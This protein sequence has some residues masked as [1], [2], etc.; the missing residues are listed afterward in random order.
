MET[1]YRAPGVV[2]PEVTAAVPMR[3]GAALAGRALLALLFIWSGIG[4]IPGFSGTVGYI[5][6]QGLPMPT[7][8]AALAVIVELG[9]GLLLLVGLKARWAALVLGLFLLVITP[10]FH[11]WWNVP[12]A[13][14][15]AQ[16]INFVK[17][18][19]ILGGMLLVWGFGPGRYSF[20][21]G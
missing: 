2:R 20:D 8:L 21:R 11:A 17:N 7:V 18:V 12:E 15:T 5:A 13:Q 16:Q 1:T 10:V 19:A 3:D 14:V 6:S 4:K 9:G